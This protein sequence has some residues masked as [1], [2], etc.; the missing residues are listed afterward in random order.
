MYNISDFLLVQVKN[1][2]YEGAASPPQA[3]VTS[4]LAQADA[5][6]TDPIPSPGLLPSPGP[7]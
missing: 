5:A 7:D 1:K 2:M 3:G 6:L 4:G